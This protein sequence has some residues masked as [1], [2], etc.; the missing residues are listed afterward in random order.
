MSQ[1][2]IGGEC[3]RSPHQECIMRREVGGGKEREAPTHLIE[4]STFSHAARVTKYRH[5]HM[6][7]R[8]V[9]EAWYSQSFGQIRN[10]G[11]KN[12]PTS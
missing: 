5:N 11:P 10:K 7:C 12:S 9:A 1:M 2:V 6:V 3:E 8:Q 4:N